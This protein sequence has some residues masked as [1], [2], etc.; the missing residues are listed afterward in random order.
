MFAI[1]NRTNVLTFIMAVLPVL[2]E[3]VCQTCSYTYDV[4]TSKGDMGIDYGTAHSI[5]PFTSELVTYAEFPGCTGV[6]PN[7]VL[8]TYPD[9]AALAVHGISV[10]RVGGSSA[11][12][13]NDLSV[14]WSIKASN[15]YYDRIF[16][17][18]T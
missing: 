16:F 14:T 13:R 15:P 1:K 18:L 9:A 6:A 8:R 4:R 11:T 17:L 2:T 5:N 7:V 10:V 12:L 3:S